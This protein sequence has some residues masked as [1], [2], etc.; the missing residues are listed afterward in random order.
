MYKIGEFSM[1][2][3]TTVK[4]LRFY[5]EQGLIKPCFVDKFT[6]YRYY[7]TCQLKEVADIVA[8]REIGLSIKEI[9]KI[10]AGENLT[11]ILESRKRA[12]SDELIA[13]KEQLRKIDQMLKENLMQQ[14]ITV[15][16]IPAY[17]VYYKDGV[18]KDFSK[19]TD[20]VLS[21]GYECSQLNPTL[22]CYTPDYCFINYLDGEYR[23]KDIKIRYAQAVE[24]A[25]VENESIKFMQIAP[26]RAVCIEHRG[27]YDG[28]RNAYNAVLKYVEENGFEACDLPRECYIDGCWNKDD[29]ED[30]LTEIQIPVK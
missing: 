29:P 27:A 14:K 3:K 16:D 24:A 30:Y 26:V 22:K 10:K 11:K 19:I 6:G 9:K 13:Y 18:I 2:S 8:L 5:E 1:L 15:K 21:A 17:T 28:L 4:A 25:G 7:E 23:E 20:F 12:I